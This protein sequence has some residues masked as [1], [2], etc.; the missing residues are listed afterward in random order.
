MELIVD[1]GLEDS[2]VYETIQDMGLMENQ[3]LLY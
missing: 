2:Q 1:T 3:I